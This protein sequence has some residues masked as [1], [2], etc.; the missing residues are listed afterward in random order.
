MDLRKGSA[1]GEVE[2]KG[3]ELTGKSA[4][5]WLESAGIITNKNSVPNDDRSPFVTSGLR[6]GTPAL[7][8]RGFKESQIEQAADFIDRVLRS[9]GDSKVGDEIRGEVVDLCQQFPMP[10]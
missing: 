1:P 9:G 6:L 5:Q 4:A 10:H 7:T 2:D 8:T 3:E